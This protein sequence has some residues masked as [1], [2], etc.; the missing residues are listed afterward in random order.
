[1]TDHPE[2]PL[3]MVML[4]RA[5]VEQALRALNMSDRV[6]YPETKIAIAALESSY[7]APQPEHLTNFQITELAHRICWKYRH[8][9]D[10]MHSHTYTFNLSTLLQFARAIEAG[11]AP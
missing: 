10:P 8:S 6:F 1:M 9:S 2:Q 7:C 4:P 3:E 11:E 5:A